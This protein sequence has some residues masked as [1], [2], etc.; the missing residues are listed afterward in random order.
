MGQV[1]VDERSQTIYHCDSDKYSWSSK[2]FAVIEVF[3]NSFKAVCLTRLANC[4]NSHWVSDL[5]SGLCDS[6]YV[7][8]LQICSL[9]FRWKA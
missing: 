4:S 5:V 8:L 1:V 7:D 3:R 9:Q 6:K 2:S